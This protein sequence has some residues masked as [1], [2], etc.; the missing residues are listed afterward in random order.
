MRRRFGLLAGLASLAA[1]W[2]WF[3]LGELANAL[4]QVSGPT[5]FAYLVCALAVA[6]GHALRWRLIA[7]RLGPTPPVGQLLAA[8]LA[9]SAVSSLVPSANLAGEPV[10]VALVR[11]CGPDGAQASAGVT[12]DRIAELIGN[13]V[14]AIAYVSVFL[15]TRTSYAS[16]PTPRVLLVAMVLGLVAVA[17][18]LVRLRRGHRPF[19]W[20]HRLVPRFLVRFDAWQRFQ[21][22]LGDFFRQSFPTFV[23]ALLGSLAIEALVIA[24]YHFLL[25]AFAIHL[26]L[27]TL[28]MVLLGTGLSNAVPTPAGIGA[29]EAGQVGVLT[30][31]SGR[32]DLGFVVGVIVRLHQSLWLVV[33]LVILAV[34]GVSWTSLDVSPVA[35][36]AAL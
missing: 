1:L 24:E 22:L 31:A 36:K 28:L 3:G 17:V 20:L 4:R 10:R 29:L 30:L 32:P 35:R 26:D 33:G 12:I 34:Q 21:E 19:A 2:W 11:R 27:P 23:V 13:M 25:A 6:V 9:G 5:L 14:C 15:W 8:R 7:S 16:S 18:P